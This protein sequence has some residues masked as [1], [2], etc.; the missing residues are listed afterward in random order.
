MFGVISEFDG[1][2]FRAIGRPL[3]A[4][5]YVSFLDNVIH[6]M[7]KKNENLIFIDTLIA[8]KQD[9]LKKIK[10]DLGLEESLAEKVQP[11]ADQY[12]WEYDDDS[13][14][15]EIAYENGKPVDNSQASKSEVLKEKISERSETEEN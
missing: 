11:A 14:F 5:Q 15:F 7:W 4:H 10:I 13:F 1:C 6:P 8:T 12:S 3:I 2:T 9:E